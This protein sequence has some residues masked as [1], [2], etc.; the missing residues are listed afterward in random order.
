MLTRMFRYLYVRVFSNS[1]DVILD[2]DGQLTSRGQHEPFKLG[3]LARQL[4]LRK[5][6][7]V[8]DLKI[9]LDI[10]DNFDAASLRKE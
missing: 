2:L 10:L 7:I 5:G 3:Q 8:S 1:H 4:E 6:M 9:K